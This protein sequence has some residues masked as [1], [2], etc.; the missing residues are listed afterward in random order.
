MKLRSVTIFLL[1]WTLIHLGIWL[2]SDSFTWDLD[3]RFW[4]PFLGL[5]Y[6]ARRFYATAEIL[7]Y[8]IIPWGFWIGY[9]FR[10]ELMDL[11]EKRGFLS[12]LNKMKDR[13]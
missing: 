1:F 2:S 13:L 10:A 5:E 3:F 7:V 12:F 9:L 8:V 11:A 4:T 6:Y